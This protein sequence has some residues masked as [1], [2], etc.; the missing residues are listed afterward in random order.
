MEHPEL[1]VVDDDEILLVILGKMI[2]KVN[3]EINV[4]TF[5]K[6][7]DALD[8]L[9]NKTENKIRFL[10]VDINLRDMDGWDFLS[11]LEARQDGFSKVILITSS[12]S[13]HNPI[14]A[15]RYPNVIGFFEKPITFEIIKKIDRIILDNM[16]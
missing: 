12:V 7:R 16:D 6:G 11:E 10:L 2:A 14:T 9:Q 4:V 15:A 1:L 3:P 5:S 13:S 8:F